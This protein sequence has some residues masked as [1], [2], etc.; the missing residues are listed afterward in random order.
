[1]F[2]EM[3]HAG[4]AHKRKVLIRNLEI[5]STKAPHL[6]I[7]TLKKAW[8]ELGLDP[9]IRAEDVPLDTWFNIASHLTKSP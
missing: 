5:L 8:V 2:F 9:K 4:F 6:T 7:Y 1:M 3:L